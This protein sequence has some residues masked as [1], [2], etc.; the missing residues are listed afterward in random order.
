M[1]AKQSATWILTAAIMLGLEAAAT[2]PGRQLLCVFMAIVIR[3]FR[4]QAKNSIVKKQRKWQNSKVILNQ[5]FHGICIL[6]LYYCFFVNSTNII[7]CF[8]CLATV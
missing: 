6:V 2:R 5:R 1:S 7:Y 4:W 8:Q 3:C